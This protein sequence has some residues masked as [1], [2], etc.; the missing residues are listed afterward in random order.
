[1]PVKSKIAVVTGAASGIGKKIALQYT[2]E[3]AEVFI[4]DINEDSVLAVG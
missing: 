1:M 4:A 3:A 2:R